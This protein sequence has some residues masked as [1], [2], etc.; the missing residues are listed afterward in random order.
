MMRLILS[1][2]LLTLV[3]ALVLA[4]FDPWD[5]AI[6]AVLAIAL[7]L[8]LRRTEYGEQLA[9]AP[10][11]P[12]RFFA[13]F[14]FAAA[15][16]WDIL[17][18]TWRVLAFIVTH[19]PAEWSDIVEVPIGERTKLGV[20]VS[21][22]AICI[23]PGSTVLEIDWERRVMV[24]HVLDARDPEAVRAQQQAFYERYQRHIFP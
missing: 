11:T 12:R 14:P 6:G 8:L 3:Y 20:A 23:S 4:S 2:I 9:L 7:Q 16:L 5:L 10:G 17:A 13:F 21:A 19:R 24:L 1:A 18:S 15:I 22:L